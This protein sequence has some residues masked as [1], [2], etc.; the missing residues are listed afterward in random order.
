MHPSF[1]FCFFPSCSVD[2]DHEWRICSSQG[3]SWDCSCLPPFPVSPLTSAGRSTPPHH[4]TLQPSGG[5]WLC[6]VLLRNCW[7]LVILLQVTMVAFVVFL[8]VVEDNKKPAVCAPSMTHA[9]SE[10]W[11]CALW[12]FWWVLCTV[13]PSCVSWVLGYGNVFQD[14]SVIHAR[15]GCFREPEPKSTHSMPLSFCEGFLGDWKCL[16]PVPCLLV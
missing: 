3:V 8:P 10:Y 5:S 13:R 1:L 11:F 4:S 14:V 12:K 6:C 7:S 16:K 9:H 2:V 15:I